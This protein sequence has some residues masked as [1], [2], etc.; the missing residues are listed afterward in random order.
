M[1]NKFFFSPCGGG[2]LCGGGIILFVNL[3][4]IYIFIIYLDIFKNIYVYQY[5][6][7]GAILNAE[8]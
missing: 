4:A 8:I 3:Y 6:Q 5:L 1:K 2:I 7:R